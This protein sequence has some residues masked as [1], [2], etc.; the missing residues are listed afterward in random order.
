[1]V[2]FVRITV[3]QSHLRP[4]CKST[5]FNPKIQRT[6][7]LINFQQ[8][9]LHVPDFIRTVVEWYNKCVSILDAKLILTCQSSTEFGFDFDYR[10]SKFRC[11][12]SVDGGGYYWGIKCLSQRICKNVQGKL[13]AI[14]LN[15]KYGFHNN[16]EN[17]PE[18]VVSDYA[19]ESDIVERFVTLTSIIIQQPEV[20]LYQ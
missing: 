1:M 4:I 19:S 16:E 12:V 9:R 5:K 7:Y 15:S 14:V 3:N 2:F 8:L 20:I 6:I 10:K 17:A 13:K 11:E 18:W